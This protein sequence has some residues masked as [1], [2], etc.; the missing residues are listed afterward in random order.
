MIDLLESGK[1]L[2]YLSFQLGSIPCNV[3]LAIKANIATGYEGIPVGAYISERNRSGKPWNVR[4]S[5][6]V[7]T[8]S[9]RMINVCNLRSFL[10]TQFRVDPIHH[11]AEITGVDEKCFSTSIPETVMLLVTREEPEACGYLS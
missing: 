6:D 9:P 5:P 11:L 10:L 3:R 2:S 7:V 1:D 8:S 4:E